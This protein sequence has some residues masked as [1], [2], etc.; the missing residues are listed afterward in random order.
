MRSLELN[1]KVNEEFT[2]SMESVPTTGYVW[3]AKFDG[4]MIRLKDKSFDASQPL[5][6]GGGGIETFTFVPIAAGETEITMI[7]KRSWER[8]A[9]EEQSYLIRIR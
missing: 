4:G 6:I 1:V 3:D 8:E 2:L 5:T 7:L 9:A